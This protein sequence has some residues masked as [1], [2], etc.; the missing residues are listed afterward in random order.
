MTTAW[1]RDGSEQ[2][3]ERR[4]SVPARDRLDRQDHGPGTCGGPACGPAAGPYVGHSLYESRELKEKKRKKNFQVFVPPGALRAGAT[5]LRRA[6]GRAPQLQGPWSRW[7]RWSRGRRAVLLRSR[8]SLCVLQ[9]SSSPVGCLSCCGFSGA[10]APA[11]RP[12]EATAS[13]RIIVCAFS[14]CFRFAFDQRPPPL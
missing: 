2:M 10:A 14:S 9:G 5:S 3:H 11:L 4:T 7:S 8:L 1:P 12:A 13:R 6:P